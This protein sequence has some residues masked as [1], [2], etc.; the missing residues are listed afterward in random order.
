MCMDPTL[1]V[2]HHRITC[3]AL[4]W[5]HFESI[6]HFRILLE[7]LPKLDILE[8]SH[9]YL[10]DTGDTLPPMAHC[11]NLRKLRILDVDERISTFLG[12]IEDGT[13][14]PPV[15]VLSVALNLEFIATDGLR[16]KRYQRLFDAYAE[17]V[18]ELKLMLHVQNENLRSGTSFLALP[19]DVLTSRV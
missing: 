12:N 11:S 17:S 3:L 13:H 18:C 8:C 10:D 16:W 1:L 15:E 7:A 6:V 5:V 14:A 4:V 2:M 9:V 19:S